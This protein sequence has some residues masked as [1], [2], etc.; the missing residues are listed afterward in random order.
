[1]EVCMVPTAY[2][3]KFCVG[4]WYESQC[5]CDLKMTNSEGRFV[6]KPKKQKKIPSPEVISET[7]VEIVPEPV[8]EVREQKKK[9][10]LRKLSFDIDI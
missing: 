1:M 4:C 10:V 9:K 3:D 2:L 6:G 7:V 5:S 8:I